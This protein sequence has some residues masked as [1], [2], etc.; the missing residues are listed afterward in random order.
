M[1]IENKDED[2]EMDDDGEDDV[3]LESAVLELLSA[4]VPELSPM[5]EAELHLSVAI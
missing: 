4:I 5:D 3:M 2:M 1:E